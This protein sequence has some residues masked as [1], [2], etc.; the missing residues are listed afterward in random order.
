MDRLRDPEPLAQAITE[1][2]IPIKLLILGPVDRE[3][4]PCFRAL[5]KTGQAEIR[6][7]LPHQQTLEQMAQAH[8]LIHLGEVAD[9]WGESV[10]GKLYEYIAV[11]RPIL[12]LV[13]P[14]DASRLLRAIPNSRCARPDDVK[15]IGKALKELLTRS[16]KTTPVPDEIIA[17]HAYPQLA[18]RL[19]LLIQELLSEGAIHDKGF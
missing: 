9:L 5:L 15:A 16:S 8:V 13:N 11:G 2:E 4:G 14:G 6:G 18:Q 7:A 12:S 3:I 17:R 1:L 19:H 10:A